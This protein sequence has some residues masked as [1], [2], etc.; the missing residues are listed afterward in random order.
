MGVMMG[1]ITSPGVYYGE[2]TTMVD[3]HNTNEPIVFD[4]YAYEGVTY[5]AADNAWKTVHLPSPKTFPGN[6]FEKIKQLNR[7]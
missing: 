6:R 7:K 4:S 1:Y 2:S 3:M 5:P